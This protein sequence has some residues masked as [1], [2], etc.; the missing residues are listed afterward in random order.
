MGVP[1]DAY[2]IT[3]PFRVIGLAGAVFSSLYIGYLAEPAA[4]AV[5]P[6]EL[7]PCGMNYLIY[8]ALGGHAKND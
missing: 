8:Y 6:E 5:V 2:V 7:N 4:A 3:F 1:D